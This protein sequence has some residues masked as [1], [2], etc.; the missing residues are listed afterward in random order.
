MKKK[1]TF[2]FDQ[3]GV[4][5]RSVRIIV[6]VC[7]LIILVAESRFLYYHNPKE[8][9]WLICIFYKL[10]GYYCPGCGAGR[11]CYSILH[12]EFYQAFRYNPLLCILL[13]W[14]GLYIAACALQWVLTG[15]ETVSRRIP[16][17]ITYIIM[18]VVILFGVVRNV[19]VYP[20]T[21]LAPTRV[22]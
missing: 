20:F 8:K 14:I 4:I 21:L 7:V 1:F 11:A 12:G 10:T 17:W 16:V 19:D 3:S 13:P 15:R 2:L 5:K 18:A 9:M 22:L 6:F